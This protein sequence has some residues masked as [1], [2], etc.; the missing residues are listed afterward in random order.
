MGREYGVVL[1][2]TQQEGETS[3]QLLSPSP[4]A[5]FLRPER[6]TL[7]T[8]ANLGIFGAVPRSLL[9][10]HLAATE[11]S[12]DLFQLKTTSSTAHL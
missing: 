5:S 2:C 3:S 1:Y 12:G 8:S 4:A 11:G 7:W 6:G 9:Q 10:I